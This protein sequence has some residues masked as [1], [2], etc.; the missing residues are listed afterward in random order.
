MDRFDRAGQAFAELCRVMARLRGPGGCPWDREQTLDSLKPYLIE[1]AYETLEA[2]DSDDPAEH[3]EE[4]GDLLLQIVFQAEIAQET[5]FNIEDVSES[6]RSKLVRR[7]PHVY[8]DTRVEGADE[9]VKN[10]EAIKADERPR[11]KGVLDGVPRSM[12]A[13]LRAYRMG[14]KA[15]GVGFDWPNAEGPR[16]KVLEEWDEVHAAV[17]QGESPERV[18]SEVGDVLFAMVNYARHLGVDPETALRGTIER[19][20]QRF[21]YVEG[22]LRERDEKVAD[23]SLDALSALWDEAKAHD[24]KAT[25]RESRQIVGS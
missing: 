22:A 10:W 20:H 14:E 13:L 5:S 1:E 16:A 2:M 8:G 19:F 4:L 17:E 3:C 12:S 15:A 7:H 24:A 6:I 18:A 25:S 23:T 21:R 9:V 11:D